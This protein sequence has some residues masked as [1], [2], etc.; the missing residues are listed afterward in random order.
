MAAPF[1]RR[2]KVV[3]LAGDFV[4]VIAA[5]YLS[6]LLRSGQRVNVPDYYTG[7]FTFTAFSYLVSFY[8]FDLYNIR[9]RFRSTA[10]LAWLILAVAAASAASAALFYL[11]PAYRFGRGI[12]LI[13]AVL[14]S[15]AA[16]AW[17]VFYQEKVMAAL[18]PKR[19]VIVGAG[20]PGE[21]IFEE[22]RKKPDY[23]VKGFLDD[24][25]ARQGKTV[26]DRAVLGGVGMLPDLCDRKEI[27]AAVVALGRQ[28]D[29]PELYR[30]M[31]H[32]KQCG[33]E[34][35]EM[36]TLFEGITGKLPVE[37]LRDKW[38]VYTPFQGMLRSFYTGRIKRLL[39]VS[40]SLAG[41]VL[42][43]PVTIAAALAIK[44]DSP[45]P[46]FFRQKRVGYDGMVY[47]V[48]KFRSMQDDAEANGA[49]WA[50]KKD[51]RVTKVGA[52]I[53]KMRIDELPQIWNV[54]KG[55]MSFIGPRPERPEFVKELG[56][57]IPYYFLRHTVKP[58]ITGWAQVN[59]PYGASVEDAFEKLQYDL[60]YIKNLSFFLDCMILLKTV[61][62][63]LFGRGAR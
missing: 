18:P 21:R 28:A 29:T 1:D 23:E 56:D 37:F 25:P 24:D 26:G 63:V 20:Q 12:F 9:S 6:I 10:N 61:R 54:L 27:D 57:V 50:Q 43:L 59:Y 53:R 34:I 35:Y 49:V 32:C 62:I 40:V 3:I 14:L 7:A 44:L 55:E 31:L 2:R 42:S 5:I 17:R 11:F 38:I 58:G 60:F 22:L 48:L 52:V 15:S 45:G 30:T 19:I 41:L 47:E 33:I 4:L 13:Q 16:F 8:I 51:P 39:D 36:P 46:V